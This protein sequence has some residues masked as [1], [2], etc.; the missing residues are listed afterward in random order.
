MS[1]KSNNARAQ[2]ILVQSGGIDAAVAKYDDGQACVLTVP[3]VRQKPNTQ[4]NSLPRFLKDAMTQAPKEGDT[5]GKIRMRLERNIRVFERMVRLE[6]LINSTDVELFTIFNGKM[7]SMFFAGQFARETPAKMVF[8][9]FPEAIRSRPAKKLN[10]NTIVHVFYGTKEEVLRGDDEDAKMIANLGH[11]IVV[12]D[13]D[14]INPAERRFRLDVD[15]DAVN[16]LD[17]EVALDAADRS[18]KLDFFRLQTVLRTLQSIGAK[19]LLVNGA[20]HLREDEINRL[21]SEFKTVNHGI[22]N[23]SPADPASL[24]ALAQKFGKAA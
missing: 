6:T 22:E 4:C 23:E 1:H 3:P 14:E 2:V 9:G 8:H 20:N 5:K 10:G 13:R 18:W 24:A 19:R 21:R 7:L 11:E 15:Q 12:F 17:Q 16:A